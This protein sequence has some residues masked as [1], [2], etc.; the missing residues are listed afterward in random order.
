MK[1]MTDYA[2]IRAI[3]VG[4]AR[5]GVSAARLLVSRGASVTVTDTRSG[6][7][8]G[9]FLKELPAEVNRVLGGHDGIKPGDYALAV[10][11][12]GVWWDSP[13]LTAL[14]NAGVSVISEVELACRHLTAPLIAITGAN[15]KTT[16][17][18]L[19]G[20]M[21]KAGGLNAFVG[22]NIGDPLCGAVGESHDWIVA[23]IS[24]FQL[25]GIVAFRPR[26][27][28]VL[29]VTPDH[30]DRHATMETYSAL[31]ARVFENQRDGDV[32]ILNAEDPVTKAFAPHKST[33]VLWFGH[34][35]HG[36]QGAWTQGGMAL[37][38]VG[39]GAVELFRLDDLKVPGSHNVE[40]ALAASLAAL[41]AGVAPAVINETIRAFNGL[42]HRMEKVAL[43]NGVT[44]IN[45]SKGTNADAT[46][47]SLSP[48]DRNVIL[49]AGG[50][51]KG[52]DFSQLAKVIRQRAKGVALIGKTAPAI[53][54]ALGD[55][56]PK[57]TAIDMESAIRV[58]TQM[59]EPG[60]TVLLS[61]ACASFDMFR[62]YEHRGDVFREAVLAMGKEPAPWR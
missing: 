61:P 43:I 52:A 39:A 54:D 9:E 17:T 41:S 53:A 4:L 50:S 8:L 31:K 58:A 62:N 22:G 49:I 59:A 11:S 34:A 7:E 25:E 55:F 20:M 48:Y 12:P 42:P 33:R 6:A 15:G 47:K 44:Y 40:N 18:T 46:V 60:D 21:L 2:G 14:R 13:L 51:S 30:M 3:V 24:S 32:V 38:D 23:E 36:K 10:T 27:S 57:A 1:N 5:S 45:D 28:L 16:T 56:E 29:N 37:A 26:I 35:P 19:T